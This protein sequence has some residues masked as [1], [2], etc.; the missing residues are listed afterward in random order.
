MCYYCHTL[1]NNTKAPKHRS[2]N[3]TNSKNTYSKNYSKPQDQ[4]IETVTQY[5][6]KC[7]RETHHCWH[8]NNGLE[9]PWLRC[10]GNC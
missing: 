4:S 8:Q 3:C 7:K 10:M 2:E 1:K 5:C 9:T 6:K